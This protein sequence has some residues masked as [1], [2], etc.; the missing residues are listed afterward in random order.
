MTRIGGFGWG[1]ARAAAVLREAGRRADVRVPRRRGADA[2]AGLRRHPRWSPS[3]TAS[4]LRPRRAAAA[5]RPALDRLPAQLRHAF[6][7]LPRT[8]CRLGARSAAA[9][10]RRGVEGIRLPGRPDEVP[11]GVE[12]IDCTP[13][14]S[15]VRHRACSAG[16]SLR[17]ARAG[18]ADPEGAAGRTASTRAASPCCR[19]RSTSTASPAQG[20][21]PA[22]RVPRPPRPVQAP[23]AVR[24]ARPLVPGRRFRDARPVALPRPPA[25][26]AGR[27]P[28]QPAAAR[29][30]RRRGEAPRAR[31][32]LGAREHPVHEALAVSFQE[33]LASRTPLLACVDTEG[34]V[35]RFGVSVGPL[36]GDGLAALP[37]LRD[38]LA[39]CSATTRYAAPRG[40]GPRLGVRPAH[41]RSGSSLRFAGRG[42][43]S[44]RSC[45]STTTRPGRRRR[46]ADAPAP[47]RAAGARPRRPPVRQLGGR[48]GARRADEL[49][50]GTTSA[51]R[52]PLQAANPFAKARL[53]RVLAEFRPDVVHVRMFL[54]QL[55]PLILP[56]LREVPSV[57]PRRLVLGRLPPRD[58]AA[59]RRARLRPPGRAACL[60]EGCLS[61]RAWPP[62]MLQLALLRRRLPAFTRVDHGQRVVPPPARRE[63]FDDVQ[64]SATPSQERPAR[65]PLAGPP[66]VAFAGRLVFE[67]GADVLVRAFAEVGPRCRTRGSSSAAT[68]RSVR[69]SMPSCASSASRGAVELTGALDR[70]A[71]EQRL[72]AGMGARDAG[73]LDGAVRQRRLRGADAR[74][75]AR[76][77]GAGRR[78][79]AR[80]RVGRGRR[81]PA[82]RRGRARRRAGRPAR[83]P[84]ALRGRGPPRPRLGAATSGTRAT[85]A[86][87]SG[88]TATSWRRRREPGL[89]SRSSSRRA[90]APSSSCAACGR[91]RRPTRRPRAW[92]S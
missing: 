44:M 17:L 53:R 6:K 19:T 28:A 70:D 42:L 86:R 32:R 73:T 45:W 13:L 25:V 75:D 11:Q 68:G 35:S 58:E 50:F 52:T 60:R 43:R 56:L 24:R 9:G 91:S 2:A 8:P 89:R 29:Q 39:A 78:G 61:A 14:R 65:P 30:P 4:S 71:L 12:E 23:L 90:T 80:R 51:L 88:S 57:L 77:D 48:P 18:R 33:A 36:P 49:C 34:V 74:H 84:R 7:A 59:P 15:M 16:R 5:G 40:R 37:S 27:P 76:G 83:R 41:A 46:A 20:A 22:R 38:G 3:T 47:L 55:S 69:G 85:S 87:S 66:T 81:R 1:A 62:T 63:G 67:K 72:G 92:R 82:R 10:G 21:A 79:R 64:C 54:T 31:P 26:G